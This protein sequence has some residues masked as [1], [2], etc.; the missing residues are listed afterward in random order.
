MRRSLL[1]PH[2][3]HV[4]K[5]L[6]REGFQAYP[7][8]GC[9][10][11]LMLGRDPEDWDVCTSALPEQTAELFPRV[12]LS[13]VK[14]GT[15][16]VLTK[17]SAVEVTTFRTDGEYSDGR[18]PDGVTFVSDLEQDLFRRDYT[19]NAMAMDL[20]YTIIDPTGGQA[21]L[22]AKLLRVVGDPE[23]RFTEDALRILRGLRQAAQLGFA[24]D[25]PALAAMEKCA[26]LVEQISDERLVMELKKALLS[27]NPEGVGEFARL[28]L[29]DRFAPVPRDADWKSLRKVPAE[30]VPR[31]RALV[32]LTGLPIQTMPVGRQVKNAILYPE[33]EALRTLAL[34][35]NELFELGYTR[36]SIGPTRRKLA[37]HI[38]RHPEDNTKE[39]LLA[40]LGK[41]N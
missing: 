37:Q 32:R 24:I 17:G 33:R 22:R 36:R 9:V 12:V 35:G 6:R 41:A 31:W 40:F 30:P 2:A 27:R 25:P 1:P 3:Y 10:R 18:H 34:S 19:V 38:I 16:T 5:V 11:D 39:K 4:C 15:V 7:V 20:D 21:D 13:G 14:H 8:G 26:P 23:T 28:G 29:L